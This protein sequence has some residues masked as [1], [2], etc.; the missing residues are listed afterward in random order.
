MKRLILLTSFAAA[1]CMAAC[2]TESK[3]ATTADASGNSGSD[4]KSDAAGSGDTTAATDTAT[5]GDTASAGDSTTTFELNTCAKLGDCVATACG[6]T[7]TTDC[8]K[9]C[10]AKAAPEA[11]SKGAVLLAC[12][13]GK[14]KDGACKGSTDP[15]CMDDCLGQQCMGETIACV[16][17]AKQGTV[18]C[19]DGIQCVQ[20]CTMGKGGFQCI[21]DCWSSMTKSGQ[22][23]LSATGKC[24]ADNPGKGEQACMAPMLSCVADGKNGTKACYE[25]F[26]CIETCKASGKDE[27]E[28]SMGCA[29]QGSADGIKGFADVAACMG[30]APNGTDSCTTAFVNCAA[31]SGTTSCID[32]IGCLVK[33]GGE[34]GKG[35]SPACLFT[36][37]HASTKTAAAASMGFA[38]CMDNKDPAKNATCADLGVTCIAPSGSK[39]CPEMVTCAMGCGQNSGASC[40]F[41]CAAQ[42]TTSSAKDFMTFAMCRNTCQAGCP[43]DDN[44]C[45]N[46][47]MV[48]DCPTAVGAC[49]PK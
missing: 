48:K 16:D 15:K 31:P 47:C 6:P 21:A 3:T 8:E 1:L 18:T 29:G 13:Q 7:P 23:L 30:K 40:I 46:A 39:T 32:T 22:T 20:K 35:P 10:F 43:K 12:M 25:I 44:T 37:L 26:G 9:P 45:L 5:T 38:G 27:G 49:A 2:G 17:M 36:C 14:C 19:G 42:G 34:A 11:Q 33:C 24:F 4:A 28:C 41:G